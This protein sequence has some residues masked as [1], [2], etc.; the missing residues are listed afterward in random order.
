MDHENY[1]INP[2]TGRLLKKGSKLHLKLIKEQIMSRSTKKGRPEYKLESSDDEEGAVPL[3]AAH[4]PQIVARVKPKHKLPP[5][6]RKHHIV[7]GPQDH[8]RG[9][10]TPPS[11]IDT[12]DD[13]ELSEL[14]SYI[15]RK[16]N[17]TKISEPETETNTE[18]TSESE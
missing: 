15:Q 11:D 7:S 3:K 17:K 6:P 18:Y 14:E 12:M 9:G 10:W 1:T 5:P 2:N 13:T 8:P 16:L 4:R